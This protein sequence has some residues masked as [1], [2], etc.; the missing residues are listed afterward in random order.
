M[1]AFV[2][3]GKRVRARWVYIVCW[4][5]LIYVICNAANGTVILVAR[6]AALH[7]R[8]CVR[9]FACT[10]AQQ[11]VIIELVSHMMVIEWPDGYLPLTVTVLRPT[12]PFAD[13]HT[14]TRT[15]NTHRGEHDGVHDGK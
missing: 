8:K 13:T 11:K 12:V 9:S 10:L 1:R 7:I 6:G 14:F 2:S 3:F 5:R 15:Y 4:R